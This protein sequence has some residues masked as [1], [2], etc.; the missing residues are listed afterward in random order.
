MPIMIDKK[1][2]PQNHVCPAVRVCPVNALMQKGYQAPV[3]NQ[4]RCIQCNKC[5]N[6]CPMEAIERI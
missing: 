6:Y 2:C 4:E 1:R 3:V 5:V